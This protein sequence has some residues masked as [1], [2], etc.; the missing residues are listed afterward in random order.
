MHHRKHAKTVTSHTITL[1]LEDVRAALYEY[2]L[3]LT[4][5]GGK[6]VHRQ[7]PYWQ[8]STEGSPRTVSDICGR[9]SAGSVVQLVF[10]T[11]LTGPVEEIGKI[12]G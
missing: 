3:K 8:A 1:D 2:A 10:E 7:A 11:E 4:A 12:D 6:V 5:I 9:M